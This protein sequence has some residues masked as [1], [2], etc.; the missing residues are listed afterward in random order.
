MGS[1]NPGKRR[2]RC[3][4]EGENFWRYL[5][6]E[7]R[8]FA[9]RLDIGCGRKTNLQKLQSCRPEQQEGRSCHSRRWGRGK[10]GAMQELSVR[11]EV[12]LHV[13]IWRLCLL[14]TWKAPRQRYQPE[15]CPH[16]DGI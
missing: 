15:G 1:Y 11:F 5:E 6:A 14:G 2:P 16:G 3:G 12:T 10:F 9:D 13:E 7:T 8:M 4:P